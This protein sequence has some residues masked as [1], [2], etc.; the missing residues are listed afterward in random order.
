MLKKVYKSNSANLIK[1]VSSKKGIVK[2]YFAVFGNKD[3][4][5]DIIEPGAFKKS[6]EERGPDGSDRI[7]HF[8]NHSTWDV[9]GKLLELGEDE[10][11][12]W[13]LSQLSKSTLGRDTLIEYQEGIITEHS[14]G[15]QVMQEEVDEAG[16]NHIKESRLWEVSTLTAWG[17]NHLT[18]TEFV[19][20]I[21]SAEQ[22]LA[23]MKRLTSYLKV[24]RFSDELLEKAE[25]EYAELSAAYKSL[26]IKMEP[27]NTHSDDEPIDLNNVTKLLKQKR[28]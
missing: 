5:N 24:G 26:G 15:F 27:E 11:G 9:P 7:K 20:E 14:H 28:A 1:D 21:R 19:K 22:F 6:I 13:F 16:T 18:N 4:D 12:G 23:E 25:K 17:A 10:K 8:K 2:A 3:S